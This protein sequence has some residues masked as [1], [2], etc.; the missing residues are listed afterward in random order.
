LTNFTVVDEGNYWETDDEKL[1]QNTFNRY[2]D[3]IENFTSSINNFPKKS[4]E[5][6]ED[7][8]ERLLKKLQSKI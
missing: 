8:F 1:L 2:T 4:G 3:L 6:L 5:S 7:Y